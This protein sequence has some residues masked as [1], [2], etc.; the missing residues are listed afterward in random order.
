MIGSWPLSD[1]S[2]SYER[3]NLNQMRADLSEALQGVL[4]S[5]KL[6][7]Y[8]GGILTSAGDELLELLPK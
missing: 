1:R 5:K 7:T 3:R 6:R 2:L 8:A 4:K